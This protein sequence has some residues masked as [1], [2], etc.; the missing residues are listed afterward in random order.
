MSF[1][2]KNCNRKGT[3]SETALAHPHTKIRQVPPPR[4][5]DTSLISNYGMVDAL[6]SA[7]FSRQCRLAFFNLLCKL[8]CTGGPAVMGG[9]GEGSQNQDSFKK[10][11]AGFHANSKGGLRISLANF[12]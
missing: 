11:T 4:V 6:K 7:E 3:A 10:W 5:F 2:K 12:A 1:S 8:G 9:G